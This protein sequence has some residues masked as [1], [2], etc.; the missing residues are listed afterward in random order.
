MERK[1]TPKKSRAAW[2]TGAGS[3]SALAM[4]HW[5]RFRFWGPPLG[6][7]GWVASLALSRTLR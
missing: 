6:K 2:S 4:H 3:A 1:T 5:E 7:S